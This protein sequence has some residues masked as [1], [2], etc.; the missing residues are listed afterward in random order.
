MANHRRIRKPDDSWNLTWERNS[1]SWYTH[2]ISDEW[3]AYRSNPGQG[4]AESHQTVSKLGWVDLGWPKVDDAETHG[5]TEFTHHVQ[6]NEPDV[7]CGWRGCFYKNHSNQ[8]VIQQMN[9]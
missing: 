7:Q 1:F 5:H 2:Y 8:V 4:G 9:V 3:C 6:S